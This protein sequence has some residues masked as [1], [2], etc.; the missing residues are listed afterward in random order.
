MESEIMLQFSDL[1]DLKID[2]VD[3]SK[4]KAEETNSSRTQEAKEANKERSSY[5]ESINDEQA[6]KFYRDRLGAGEA[7]IGTLKNT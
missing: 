1:E 6:I 4:V 5:P 7:V 3:Q 2:E